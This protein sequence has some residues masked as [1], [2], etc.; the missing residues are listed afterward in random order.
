MTRNRASKVCNNNFCLSCPPPTL[1]LQLLLDD[2]PQDLPATQIIVPDGESDGAEQSF[3]TGWFSDGAATSTR[4]DA[5]SLVTIDNRFP[6]F[7][8]HESLQEMSSLLKKDF[9]IF[10]VN[11]ALPAVCFSQNLYGDYVCVCV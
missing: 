5:S 3:L 6:C 9:R 8:S 4:V 11:N 10:T 7:L 1:L 2:R